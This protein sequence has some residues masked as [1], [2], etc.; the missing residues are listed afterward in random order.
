LIAVC[1]RVQA[2]MHP[3]GIAPGQIGIVGVGGG[4]TGV[5]LA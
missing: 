4:A 2:G 5:G 1:A 3:D